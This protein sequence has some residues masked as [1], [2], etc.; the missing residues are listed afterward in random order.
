MLSSI[1]DP[2]AVPVGASFSIHSAKDGWPIRVFDWPQPETTPGKLA[3][4]PRGS[5]LFQTGRGDMIEKWFETLVHWH[6][7][8]WAIT[9]FDWRGQGGSGRLIAD[10]TTG[11]IDDFRTWTAD[12]AEFWARWK[13]QTPAPHVVIGHSMGGHLVLRSVMEGGIDP[14]ALLL[15]APMLGF[16]TKALPVRWVAAAVRLVAALA[17]ERKAWSSNERPSKPDVRRRS[18]LTHDDKRY[19][20]ELW[21]RGQHPELVLGPPSLRWL[22]AAYQST[23]WTAAGKRLEAIRTPVLLIGTDGDQLV[24]PQAIRRVAARIPK[25]QLKMFGAGVAHEILREV[26]SVRAEA[27]SEID[28]YLENSAPRHTVS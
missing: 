24:S 17:P 28:A 7:Q 15:S 1:F 26:D 9:G 27:L 3:V 2:R 21:W 4:T 12:L 23:L 11:H 6:A 22:A 13:T 18:F 10:P 20:D 5:I 14:D 16:E 25:A 8:G 19:E